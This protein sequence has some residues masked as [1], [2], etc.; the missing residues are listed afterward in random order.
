M[1]TKLL[2]DRGATFSPCRTY[3]YRLWRTWDEDGATLAVIGLNPSTADETTDDPTIRRCLGFARAWGYG[4]LLMVNLFAYRSTDPQ[5]LLT[6][7]DPIGPENDDHL[8]RAAWGNVL[9]AWGAHPLAR[10]RAENVLRMLNWRDVECLG[11]TKSGAPKH[12]LYIA[13]STQPVVYR[14]AR[15]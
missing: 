5:G 10:E 8:T 9:A 4:S 12:P 13:A 2:M 7:A 1:T 3:R 14:A 11:V 15:R 6:V